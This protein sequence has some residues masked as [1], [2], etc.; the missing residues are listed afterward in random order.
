MEKRKVIL[1]GGAPLSGKSTLAAELSKRL[2]IPW[3]STDDIRK[4]MEQIVRK[5]DYPDLFYGDGLDVVAFY[6]KF[7]TAEEIF[8][9]ENKQGDDVQKGI[10]AMIESFWWWDK[11]IIEGIAITPTFVRQFQ[12]THT[13]ISVIPVFIVD[14]NRDNIKMRLEKRG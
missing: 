9:R 4:W 7:K 12:N 6:E 2:Q 13:D 14:T 3:V 11:F 8:Q 10:K 5:E 1:I